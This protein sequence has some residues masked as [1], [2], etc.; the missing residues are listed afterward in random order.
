MQQLQNFFDNLLVNPA[1]FTEFAFRLLSSYFRK[2]FLTPSIDQGQL[3]VICEEFDMYS[4]IEE[5]NTA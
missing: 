4:K 5:A 2:H 1:T 3:A